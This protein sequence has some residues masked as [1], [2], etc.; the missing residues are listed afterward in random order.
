MKPAGADCNLRCDYCFYLRKGDLYPGTARHRMSEKTLRVVLQR[1]FETSQPIY[2]MV[3][4]GGEPTLMGEKFFRRVVNLQ[5]EIAPAG[6]RIA[7]AIQTNATSVREDLA[8]HL[9]RYRFLAG[10]SID[11]PADLHDAH[12]LT[13]TGRGSHKKAVSG[14]NTLR[15]HGVPVNGVVLVSAANVGSAQRV[16]RHLL[17]QG[18]RH[19]QF[20]PCVEFDAR[21]RPLPYT[22]TGEQWGSFLLSVFEQWYRAHLGSVSIRNFESVM[23]RMAGVAETE[24][25]FCS[26]CDQY[27]VVEHN[28]DVYPCDFFVDRAH[29]LGNV[30]DHS[31][32]QMRASEY[33]RR[34]QGAVFSLFVWETARNFVSVPATGESVGCAED[35]PD[36]LT[37]PANAWHFWSALRDFRCLS[38]YVVADLNKYADNIKSTIYNIDVGSPMHAAIEEIIAKNVAGLGGWAQVGSATPVMLME[39]KSIIRSP[40]VVCTP[41]RADE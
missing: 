3:W 24:C 1:Y 7:N 33:R 36:S 34:V 20:I 31:F 39:V 32:E 6:A 5:K 41:K 12:R 30:S 29:L 28:G 40:P 25:R 16:Y 37:R 19:L 14:M 38:M 23:A 2:S 27:L 11:G 13:K 18:L 8:A 9:G 35:G 15:R 4:Q 17:E 21:G 26:R 10:C 22:I